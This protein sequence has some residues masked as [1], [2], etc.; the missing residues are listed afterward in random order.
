MGKL[1]IG[2]GRNLDDAGISDQEAEALLENDIKK[3]T[4]GVVVAL[5]WIYSMSL[6]RRAVFFNMA[7][8]MGVHGLLSFHVVLDRAEHGDYAGAADSMLNSRWARQ[9]GDR[10][11]RLAE[12]MRTDTWQ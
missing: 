6:T 9:V 12:Q 11:I 4:L 2:F 3:A 1:T 5:P 10:A 8:N 7:F